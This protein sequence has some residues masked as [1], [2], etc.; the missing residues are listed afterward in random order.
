MS[1]RWKKEKLLRLAMVDILELDMIFVLISAPKFFN[2]DRG[3][4]RSHGPKDSLLSQE[5]G[6]QARS[7]PKCALTYRARD[8]YYKSYTP[9]VHF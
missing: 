5:R 3:R 9:L 6:G 4:G 7:M 2:E 8:R 1:K